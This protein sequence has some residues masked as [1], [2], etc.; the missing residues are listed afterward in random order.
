MTKALITCGQHPGVYFL[1]KWLPETE[2][3]YG[4][5]SF[6]TQIPVPQQ[7][8]LPLV[9]QPDFIHQLLNIC[10]DQQI[11]SVFA[12]AA[13]EQEL[14]AEAV[15][16]FAEF[17]IQ[18]QLPNLLTRKLLLKEALLLE[19]LN[20]ASINII[21]FRTS[22]SV[23]TFSKACLALGYPSES[24]AVSSAENLGMIWIMDDQLAKTES[25]ING[26]PVIPF[27]TT[28][29]LFNQEELLLL[30]K[31]HRPT[32]KTGYAVFTGGKLVSCWNNLSQQ[33]TQALNQTAQHLQLNG[34][35]EFNFQQEQ[36]LFG[37]KPFVVR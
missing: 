32:F 7:L 16:L 13:A 4:D 20:Q 21:P 11:E 37:I 3:I 31:F 5:A 15:E 33:K 10:L 17:N 25:S 30:R 26:K 8:L 12:M 27:T 22:A 35:F 36:Q 1:G 23:E 29:K 14:L 28:L 24:I 34:L 6:I 2:F 18:L 19:N 9:S